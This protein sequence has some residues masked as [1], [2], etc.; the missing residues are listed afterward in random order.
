[1]STENSTENGLE[2]SSADSGEI[3]TGASLVQK[4]SIVGGMT[5]ISRILGLLRDVVFAR[6][7]GASW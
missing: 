1:M 6:F 7:F 4:T 3:A 5:L 2:R